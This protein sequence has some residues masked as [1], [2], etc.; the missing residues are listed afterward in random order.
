MA[1]S[2][3]PAKVVLGRLYAC[4]YAPR[5]EE[6]EGGGEHGGHMEVALHAVR[7]PSG[8]T[9]AVMSASTRRPEEQGLQSEVE[10]MVPI[11][12]Y[13]ARS[14]ALIE[15]IVRLVRQQWGRPA[16]LAHTHT[17]TH[18][19]THIHTHT[20]CRNGPTSSPSISRSAFT[21]SPPSATIQH[22]VGQLE[23]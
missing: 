6:S 16:T 12:P 3:V 1:D 15:A 10:R 19:H 4:F 2:Q 23:G 18:T 5:A 9:S 20:F 13:G 14:Q 7:Q 17:H 21:S 8:R 11:Q 22:R